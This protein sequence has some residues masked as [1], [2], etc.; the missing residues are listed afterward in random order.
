MPCDHG[1]YRVA[2]RGAVKG[3]PDGCERVYRTF[4]THSL[5]HIHQ[6]K[7]IALEIAAKIASVNGPLENFPLD[8]VELRPSQRMIPVIEEILIWTRR[9]K[10]IAIAGKSIL[11]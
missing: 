10:Y 7:K 3:P 6:K 4:I 2:A 11:K 8:Q 5:V 9:T 1:S